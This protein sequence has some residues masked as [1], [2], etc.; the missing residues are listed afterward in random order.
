MPELN[1]ISTLSEKPVILQFSY[2]IEKAN[3]YVIEDNGHAVII[4]ACSKAVAEELKR[5]NVTPDYLILTHEHCDHLWG[6]NAIRSA[7]PNVQV[8]AQEYCNEAIGDPKRNKAKQYHIYATL[9]FGE[10]YQNEEAKNRKYACA[11]AE[12]TFKEKLELTWCGYD[13][14]FCHTPGHSPGSMLINI[15]GVGI[16][17]GDSILQEETFLKFDGGDVNAFNSITLPVIESIPD[18]TVV[19]PGH[20]KVIQMREWRKNGGTT[21]Q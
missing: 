8:V 21:E 16:F 4:D 9:R 7:F 11:A 6:V 15:D 10:E 18:K 3:T 19:F 13:I 12:I 17:S 14:V 1:G 5:R 20:G 2:G